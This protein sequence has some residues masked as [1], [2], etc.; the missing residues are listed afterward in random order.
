MAYSVFHL[1]Q[2][3]SQDNEKCN[4]PR[5]NAELIP[6]LRGA[7]QQVLNMESGRDRAGWLVSHDKSIVKVVS[8]SLVPATHDL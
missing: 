8:C 4:P 3:T 1:L 7:Y 6:V 5:A 2:M